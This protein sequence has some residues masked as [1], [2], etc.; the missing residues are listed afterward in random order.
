MFSSYHRS[1]V[2]NGYQRNS[3]HRNSSYRDSIVEILRWT[4]PE[5]DRVPTVALVRIF[6]YLTTAEKLVAASVCHHWAQAAAHPSLWRR[7][8]IN[9]SMISEDRVDLFQCYASHIQ[10]MDV[11]GLSSKYIKHLIEVLQSGY[12][13]GDH[14][15]KFSLKFP[16]EDHGS[17]S[18]DIVPELRWLFS[19]FRM[20]KTCSVLNTRIACAFYMLSPDPVGE[21]LRNA[22]SARSLQKLELV[23]YTLLKFAK[24]L[25]CISNCENLVNLTVSPQHLNESVLYSLTSIHSLRTITIVCNRFTVRQNCHVIPRS[26]W[27]EFRYKSPKVKVECLLH[28]LNTFGHLLMDSVPVNWIYFEDVITFDGLRNLKKYAGTLERYSYV[29]MAPV[30]TLIRNTVTS[31]GQTD[32]NGTSN[33]LPVF[34]SHMITFARI[35]HNLHTFEFSE[36]ISCSALLLIVDLSPKLK[37]V[38]VRSSKLV[39]DGQKSNMFR[40][41]SKA[42]RSLWFKNYASS[43]LP[44]LHQMS[45]MLQYP[46]RPLSD[47]EFVAI[48][49]KL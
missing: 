43:L 35:C 30:Q 25:L 2:R 26:R 33:L 44:F 47:A 3:I 20:L 14:L 36:V 1:F 42:Q 28:S 40:E 18:A 34:D 4:M 19:S 39:F 11:E 38:R 21:L 13:V 9:P 17:V 5:W 37:T 41:M 45:V 8:N 27:E 6:S 32:N 16:V 23:N 46:W 49:K 7:V 15:T 29:N 22:A 24:P 12:N 31:P 48:C 10:H